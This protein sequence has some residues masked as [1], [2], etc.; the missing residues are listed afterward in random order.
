LDDDV[1]TEDEWAMLDHL[2]RVIGLQENEHALI[3]EAIRAMAE[4]DDQGQRRVERLERFI[5]VCP[6]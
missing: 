6:Y 3:E 2:R 1:I 5:T 4:T